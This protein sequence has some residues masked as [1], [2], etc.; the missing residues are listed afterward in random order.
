MAQTISRLHILGQMPP[1]FEEILTEEALRFI[2]DLHAA[3]NRQRLLLLAQRSLVQADLQKGRNPTFPEET[4]HIRAANWKVCDAPDDLIERRV[5][6]TGPV[7]RK[8]MINALNS[9]ANVFMADFEDSLS[10]TWRN[11][12]EGQ[13]N[14]KEAV[15]RTLTFFSSDGKRYALKDKTAT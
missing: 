9:G 4:A 14:L 1:E 10:P 3:F 15:R 8:M 7:E 12:V 11:I 5:E 6:I 2:G 13:M